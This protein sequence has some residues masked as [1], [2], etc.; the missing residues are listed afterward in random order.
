VFA[1]HVQLTVIGSNKKGGMTTFEEVLSTR[2]GSRYREILAWDMWEHRNKA[3]HGGH[4]AQQQIL[5]SVVDNQIQILYSG[6]P[7]NLPRDALHFIAQ[8]LDIILEYSH[9]SKQ[10]WVAS[11]QAAQEHR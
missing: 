11:V 9:R 3:L 5:H 4:Q 1:L 6:G 10:Q 7:Q 2:P 8:L